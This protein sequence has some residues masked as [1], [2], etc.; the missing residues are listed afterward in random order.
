M[1]WVVHPITFGFHDH[2][3]ITRK[4]IKASSVVKSKNLLF[5]R[6]MPDRVR[7]DDLAIDSLT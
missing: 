3:I 6:W 1:H 5:D 4:E 2:S 7:H